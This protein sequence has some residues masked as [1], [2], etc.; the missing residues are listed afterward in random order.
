MIRRW[1]GYPLLT[2]AFFAIAAV[3][4]AYDANDAL[5]EAAAGLSILLGL[6][7]AAYWRQER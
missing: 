5:M 6:M 3:A 7:C 1:T 4:L 2:V